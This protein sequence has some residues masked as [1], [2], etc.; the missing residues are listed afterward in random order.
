MGTTIDTL[1]ALDGK[2][3]IGGGAGDFILFQSA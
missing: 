1:I 2:Y 3:G